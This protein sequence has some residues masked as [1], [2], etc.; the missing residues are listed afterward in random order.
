M[1]NSRFKGNIPCSIGEIKGLEFLHLSKNIFLEELSTPLLTSRISLGFLDLSINNFQGQ[2]FSKY[3]NLFQLMYLF[4]ENNKFG[5]KIEEGLSN[6]NELRE[7]DISNN[8]LSSYIPYWIHNFSSDLW[9][10][11]MSKFFLEGIYLYNS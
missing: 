9:V 10:L 3:M 6:S 2:I 7:L 4:L 5:G 8:L 1:S 11:L